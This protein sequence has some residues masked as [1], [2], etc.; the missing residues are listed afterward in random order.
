MSF[1]GFQK[2][3][4]RTR[5]SK[6]RTGLSHMKVNMLSFFLHQRAHQFYPKLISLMQVALTANGVIDDF[7]YLEIV[8]MYNL[9]KL[10]PVPSCPYTNSI[11]LDQS[12]KLR[13]KAHNT[14]YISVPLE[15]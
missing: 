14:S 13:Q 2:A 6:G 11:L 7:F 8:P 12:A 9:S 3:K 1:L 15:Q 10:C 4:G 5:L